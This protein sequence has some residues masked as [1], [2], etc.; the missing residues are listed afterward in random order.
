V[1]L[2]HLPAR[3]AESFTALLEALL[4]G[5]IAVR[6]LLSAKPRCI[7][8]ASLLLFGCAPSGLR[9]RNVTAQNQHGNCD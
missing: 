8:G 6:H 5:G 3:P 4:D 9:L 7:A 2:K 1:F